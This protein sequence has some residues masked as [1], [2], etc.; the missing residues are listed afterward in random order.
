MIIKEVT[1][2]LGR[3]I[4]FKQFEPHN[5]HISFKAEISEDEQAS[6][7]SFAKKLFVECESAIKE[8]I[9]KVKEFYPKSK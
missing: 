6:T 1:A 3:T 5:F 7:Q 2:S 4:Q 8:E 9:L